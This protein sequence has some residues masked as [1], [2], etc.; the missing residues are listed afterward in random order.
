MT[1]LKN[2][3][4]KVSAGVDQVADTI[5]GL[6]TTIA[7]KEKGIYTKLAAA[8]VKS[9]DEAVTS[10]SS[11]KKLQTAILTAIAA[12][13]YTGLEAYGVTDAQSAAKVLTKTTE[14]VNSLTEAVASLKVMDEVADNVSAKKDDLKELQDGAKELTTGCRKSCNRC[15]Y[16]GYYNDKRSKQ[17]KAVSSRSKISI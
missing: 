17:H 12:D 13:T 8:G 7:E 6:G 10:L 15:K 16:I 5:N 11:A 14:N 2:G 9:Y 3:A 4:L 1:D